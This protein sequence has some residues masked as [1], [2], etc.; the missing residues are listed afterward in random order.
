MF[1]KALV[2]CGSLLAGMIWSSASVKA[3]EA[4]LRIGTDGSFSPFVFQKDGAPAGFD[5]DIWDAAAKIMG[6]RYKLL[7]VDFISL[8]PALQTHSLDGAFAGISITSERSKLVDFSQPYY[9]SGLSALVRR[10]SKLTSS[11]QIDGARVATKQ[12]TSSVEYLKAHA[13]RAEIN[14]FPS[15]DAAYQ[16][17]LAGHVDAVVFDSPVLAYYAATVGKGTAKL[18]SPP[19]TSGELYGFAFPQDSDLAIRFD[20]ALRSMRENGQYQSIYEKWFGKAP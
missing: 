8:I 13:P 16:E 4:E 15:I 14:S 7:T 11:A 5:V 9:Q 2:V 3:A 12:A 10:D 17:L 18:L 20:A 6:V 1:S 19:L